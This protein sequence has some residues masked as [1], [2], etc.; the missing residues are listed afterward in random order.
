[1]MQEMSIT[2]GPDYIST[3]DAF[4][5]YVEINPE[6]K[7]LHSRM[8]KI[9]IK[10]EEIE[11]LASAYYLSGT[12]YREKLDYKKASSN[13]LLSAQ[14]YASFDKEFS[15]RALYGAIESFDCNSS[16]ADSKQTYLTLKEKYPQSVRTITYSDGASGEFFTATATT[17]NVKEVTITGVK[18]GTNKTLTATAG[19]VTATITVNVTSS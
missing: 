4:L 3:K 10:N 19:N 18:A 6:Y 16:F 5:E 8:A 7:G 12:Y 1:M 14:Y 2:C 11:N 17:G 13:F 15:A 9:C